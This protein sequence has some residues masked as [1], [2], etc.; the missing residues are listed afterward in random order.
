MRASRRILKAKTSY[1]ITQL[2]QRRRSRPTGKT[3]PYNDD[4]EF[5]PVVRAN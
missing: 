2:A 1:P 4:L 3:A 5:P